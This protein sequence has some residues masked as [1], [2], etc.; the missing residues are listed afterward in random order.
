MTARAVLAA[1]AAVILTTAEG[2]FE[3]PTPP[4]TGREPLDL[5]GLCAIVGEVL[6][7]PV[8]REV[9]DDASMRARFD[10]R[11]TPHRFAAIAMGFYLASRAGEFAR[12]DPIL[13]E[14]I[15]RPPTSMRSFLTAKLRG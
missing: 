14:L 7:R 5:A 4:L 9:V 8:R 11:G 10:E 2:R 13:E 1:A 12:V 6:G 3:G 15:G